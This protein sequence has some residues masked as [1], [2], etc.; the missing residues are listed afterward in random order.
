M[1]KRKQK[2]IAVRVAAN[3][4]A[5]R[6]AGSQV[7]EPVEGG[8][9]EDLLAA[10]RIVQIQPLGPLAAG[11]RQ[12]AAEDGDGRYLALLLLEELDP[13]DSARS[14]GFSAG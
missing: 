1:K 13:D 11:G 12:A 2:L 3:S 4:N 7:V 6:A 10:W 14:L 5:A 9:M 8:S